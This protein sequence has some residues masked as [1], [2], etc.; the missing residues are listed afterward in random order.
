MVGQAQ[1]DWRHV[2][3]V[4]EM[5]TRCSTT[6][7]RATII[8]FS[9]EAIVRIGIWAGFAWL[10]SVEMAAAGTFFLVFGLA[11]LDD[12]YLGITLQAMEE[13][14]EYID[15]RIEEKGSEDASL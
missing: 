14:Q 13:M 8:W 6:A 1:L 7:I 5:K 10:K 11:C 15:K 9:V 12:R 2:L 4:R 3:S